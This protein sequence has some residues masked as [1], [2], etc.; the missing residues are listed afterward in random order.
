MYTNQHLFINKESFMTPFHDLKD[1]TYISIESFR[2][3]GDSVKTPVWLTSEHNNLYCWTIADSGKVKRIRNH[4]Q[5]NLA[6]C[7]A[8][9]TIQSEWVTAIAQILDQPDDIQAQTKHM[10]KKYGLLFRLFQLMGKIRRSQHVVIRFS[11]D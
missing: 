2:K 11:P 10:V 5:V 9:G 4:P 3:S 1:A 6:Q 7:D 8:Q